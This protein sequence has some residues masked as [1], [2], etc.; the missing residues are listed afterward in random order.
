MKLTIETDQVIKS[1]NIVF[2]DSG[3]GEVAIKPKLVSKLTAHQHPNEELVDNYEP[4]TPKPT[5]GYF[6]KPT[7]KREP[8]VDETI[9]GFTA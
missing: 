7:T 5:S 9:A 3:D 8:K 1:L 2:G 4:K 6:E